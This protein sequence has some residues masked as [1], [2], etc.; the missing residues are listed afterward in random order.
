MRTACVLRRDEFILDAPL[1]DASHAV[2]PGIDDLA[3]QIRSDY[4]LAHR[5]ERRRPNS[6]TSVVSWDS[7]SGLMASFSLVGWPSGVVAWP[8]RS[9]L[10]VRTRDV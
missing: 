9:E 7:R 1:E 5:P 2:D 10:P 3:G 6:H 4:L 8:A